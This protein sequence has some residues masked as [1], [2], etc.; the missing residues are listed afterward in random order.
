MKR[1]VRKLILFT[2]KIK[3]YYKFH[4]LYFNPILVRYA[5]IYDILIFILSTGCLA[6]YY[7]I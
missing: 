1:N 5:S 2:K 6:I 4:P 7:L 3:F